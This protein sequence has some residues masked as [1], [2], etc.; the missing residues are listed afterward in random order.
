MLLFVIILRRT[1]Q[2]YQ[3]VLLSVPVITSQKTR[4]NYAK[5]ASYQSQIISDTFLK[6]I[7]IHF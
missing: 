5:V 4:F 1:K 6:Q 3:V 2:E 7:K